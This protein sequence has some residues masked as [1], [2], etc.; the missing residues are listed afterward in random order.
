MTREDIDK[1]TRSEVIGYLAIHGVT[2]DGTDDELREILKR[3][4]FVDL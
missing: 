1:M 3:V 4:I 2:A